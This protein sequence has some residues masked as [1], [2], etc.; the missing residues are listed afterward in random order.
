MCTFVIVGDAA[1]QIH[2]MVLTSVSLLL[3]SNTHCP[4]VMH[5]VTLLHA[6]TICC[7]ACTR[8]IWPFVLVL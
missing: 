3:K 1:R 8:C 6:V 7:K 4:Y 5:L 2:V